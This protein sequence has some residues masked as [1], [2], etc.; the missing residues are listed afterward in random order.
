MKRLSVLLLCLFSLWA[1]VAQTP[2]NMGD[3]SSVTGCNFMIYDNGGISG[4]Y[5][6]N[7][8]DVLTIYSDNVA[9]GCVQIAIALSNLNIDPS[10]TLYIYDGPTTSSPL[11]G[12]INDGMT[13]PYASTSII[14][15]ATIN[16]SS[17]AITLRFVSDGDSQGNG[18]MIQTDC[19]A[20]CQRVN[21]ALDTAQCSHV[22]HLESDGFFYINV[23]SYDTV[24]L[25]VGCTY[26]DNNFSY[27]QSD[28]T[29]SF[30]WNMGLELIDSVGLNTLD[31]HFIA[32]R[33]YDV[34]INAT[35]IGGCASTMP[36]VFRVRTSHTPVER[37]TN[38]S[39]VCSG[40]DFNV[41]YSYFQGAVVK[42]DSVKSE[43][44]AVLGVSD[45]IFLPDGVNC[46]SG[47]AYMSPVTFTAF[48][49]LDT[50]SSADDI[51]Y[52][53]VQ[54][55]HSYIGDIYIALTCPDGKIVKIMN[56]YGTSGSASCAGSIPVP[57][58]WLQS[59]NINAAAHFGVI[60]FANNADYKC[61]MDKNEI[62]RTW[63]YCWSNNT[64]PAYGYNYAPGNGRVYDLS[65]IHNG[66]VDSTNVT[67]M[68]HLYHP[69]E[70]F[71]GLIGCHLNGQWAIKVVDGWSGDNGYI[72][73]W[74]M[75]LDSSLLPETWYYEV[76][77]TSFSVLGPGANGTHIT[78]AQPGM[79]D[80]TIR[81]VDEFGCVYD[82]VM[83]VRVVES[84]T[85]NLGDDVHLC[86][87][88]ITTLS[89]D[90]VPHDAS[91]VWNTGDTTR[92]ILALV[93][94]DYTVDLACANEDGSLVCHGRD[95]VR[96]ISVE[97]PVIDFEM[98]PLSGCMPL[99][100]QVTNN[101]TPQDGSHDWY[102]YRQ[103]GSLAYSS[104]QMEPVFNL[105]EAGIYHVLY[106]LTTPYVCKD[107]VMLWNYIE[108][109]EQP[110]AEFQAD[111][112]I[113]MMGDFG[114]NVHFVNYSDSAALTTFNS[115]VRW[116]FGDGET[117]T[118]HFSPTHTYGSWGDYDVTLYVET[119]SGCTSE[120]THTVTI[121]QDLVFPNVITPNGDG[122]NDVFAIENLNTNI[123]MEDPD[124]FRTNQLY[125]HDRWGKLVYQADNYDTFAKDGT[126]QVGSQF[127][128]GANL[129]DGVYY[130]SFYF[131]GK[132][133]T[134]HYNGSI[135]IIR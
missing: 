64:N 131:K 39:P 114:G 133:K 55:E 80:Y 59:S 107:S 104:Q 103:D 88:N 7:R 116:D 77:M 92:E 20:P 23:C 19:I 93:D 72:T 33:G 121:E 56:K 12:M 110:I 108:A 49:P 63:N 41:T 9:A 17:G 134:I 29:T 50:I 115:L 40:A 84:P 124:G 31:Y 87:G 51:L 44:E 3:A 118:T 25:V 94:G 43:Q 68:T 14:F 38:P 4:N 127:F 119:E 120:I 32:G 83:P 53:R 71:A 52:L 112:E 97:Q 126:I 106:K 62:G 58:G 1:S 21:I 46:G 82:S 61:D 48:G 34:T 122:L 24:H 86:F 35:D 129:S 76:P 125:I 74:E 75:A 102:I 2:I 90:T 27:T 5:G 78:F 45:T 70:S 95:T 101:S 132:A 36:V 47:C 117:D 100:I 109:S 65:N 73:E 69:D 60:G 26:P 54:M 96:V 99:R 13:S 128:D 135:T 10:D 37:F 91:I 22:P 15:S 89:V 28:A 81:T 79:V 123:N 105:E 57:W 6:A 85:P 111:P 18:F 11:L 67:N 16:N 30:S 130:Y 66:I 8:N 113:S 98:D 42:L